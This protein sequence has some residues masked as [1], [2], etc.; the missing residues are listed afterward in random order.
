[1]NKVSSRRYLIHRAVRP[2][3]VELPGLRNSAVGVACRGR[4]AIL[5]T[6]H[7]RELSRAHRSD[8]PQQRDRRG[9]RRRRHRVECDHRR[10]GQCKKPASS[11]SGTFQTTLSY[12]HGGL[13]RRRG[14]VP[15][16]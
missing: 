5:E 13:D 12:R 2:G 4:E 14:Q 11:V 7:Q 16:S 15:A 8:N 3:L 9:G 6:H 10:R 1:M